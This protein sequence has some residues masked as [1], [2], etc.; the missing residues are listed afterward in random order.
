MR[1]VSWIVHLYPPV[2]RERYEEEMQALLELHT[3]TP[4]TV[5]DLC[6][7]VIR[8]W[9]DPSYRRTSLRL[10]RWRIFTAGALLGLSVGLFLF[11]AMGW[12]QASDV[13]APASLD[14]FLAGCA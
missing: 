11:A 2:W 12:I 6:L 8:A 3:I 9:L 10:L 1:L 4:F 7:S 13:N 5:I 14:T